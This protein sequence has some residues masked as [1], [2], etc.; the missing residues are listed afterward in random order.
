[1]FQ[2]HI[3]PFLQEVF[4]PIVTAIFQVLLTPVDERDQ[5]AAVEKRMLQRG[6]F[7]FIATLVNNNVTEVLSNQGTSA[8]YL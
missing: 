6:Y 5:V 8:F 7:S 3:A 1:M 4:M 2:K